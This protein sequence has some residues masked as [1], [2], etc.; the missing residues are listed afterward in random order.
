[1]LQII[2]VIFILALPA[3]VTYSLTQ[4][5]DKVR[6]TLTIFFASIIFL[7]ILA[8]VDSIF[9]YAG[10]GDDEDYYN[11]S[12]SQL[13]TLSDWFD[14]NRINKSA[15]QGGYGMLLTW[16]GQFVEDSLYLR[17]TLNVAFYL[18]LPAIWYSIGMSVKGRGMAVASFWIMLL[19]C[20]LW[21][22]WMFL[23]KDMTIVLLQSIFLLAAINFFSGRHNP[24]TVFLI[25]LSTLL[26]IPFRLYLVAVNLV[27]LGAGFISTLK[28]P[29]RKSGQIFRL[30]II[31]ACAAVI[32]IAATNQRMLQSLGVNSSARSL[33]TS[34]LQKNMVM[35][36]K[37]KQNQLQTS[38]LY[39]LKFPFLFVIG[40]TA[41]LNPAMWDNINNGENLRSFLVVP[42]IFFDVP[43]V[44]IG[45]AGFFRRDYV[46]ANKLTRSAHTAP[47]IANA[48]ANKVLLLSFLAAYVAIA[49]FSTD[50]TRWRMPATPTMAMFAA[51]GWVGL[52]PQKRTLLLFCWCMVLATLATAYYLLK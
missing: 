14:F 19:T 41:G 13:E 11:S 38:A 20:P 32:L 39:A 33:D 26:L 43:L 7:G 3:G 36:E 10:G 4:P 18:C 31:S 45:L 23:F 5:R 27:V 49:W 6:C 46:T 47:L 16:A 42:W 2:F 8:Y 48:K 34:A 44:L 21:H 9:P 35:Y 24:G 52:R 17:K 1:M 15:E 50:T 28:T 25:F 37:A 22:Y 12:L 30:L 51:L 29:T 40:E